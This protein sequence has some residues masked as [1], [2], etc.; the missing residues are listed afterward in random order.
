MLSPQIFEYLFPDCYNKKENHPLSG[1][2]FER[3]VKWGISRFFNRP[4]DLTTLGIDNCCK[5]CVQIIFFL[6]VNILH[7]VTSNYFNLTSIFTHP[8]GSYYF[9]FNVL[10]YIFTL[11]GSIYFT[12]QHAS[13]KTSRS[14]L[15]CIISIFSSQCFMVSWSILFCRAG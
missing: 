7:Y 11:S 8:L 6:M 10:A 9:C 3:I 12:I 1:S 13:V 2:G 14:F 4:G 5:L 15:K